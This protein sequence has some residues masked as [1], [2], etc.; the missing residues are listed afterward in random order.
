MH[1][2]ANSMT[3]LCYGRKQEGAGSECVPIYACSGGEAVF[4]IV[5]GGKDLFICQRVDAF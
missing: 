3:K 2:L 5:G 4:V 1:H